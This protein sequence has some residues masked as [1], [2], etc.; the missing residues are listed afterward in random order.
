MIRIIGAIV[1]VV[2]A[3]LGGVALFI[4]VQGADQRAADG[5]E[6]RQVY[7][8][9]QE[10][11]KGTAG[12][13]IS[14]FV[15][16]DELPA[17]AIQP[18]IVTDLT[19]LAG[20]VTNAS[21]LPGEQL[22]MAR[23]SDPE[24]LAAAGDVAIPDG[25]QEITIA[26]PVE[27]VVGGAIQPGSTVGVLFTNTT[28]SPASNEQ[29]AVTKFMYH[30][31]LVTKVTAGRTLVTNETEESAREVSAFLLTF[32]VTTAQAENIA[33]AAEQQDDGNGGIWLTLEPEGVDTSGSQLRSGQNVFQ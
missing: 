8:L 16:I 7:V 27:R 26:L 32:A 12:E 10:V 3:L 1:A 24:D 5:A 22:L 20:L 18:D 25:Y 13:A 23:F 33:Y 29:L 15:E 14:E 6:F 2:L 21:L 9:T 28:Q 17:L 11:P 31:V 4:Y 19:T 30:G